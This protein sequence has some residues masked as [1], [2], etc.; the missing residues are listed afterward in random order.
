VHRPP[1]S[2]TLHDHRLDRGL[3]FDGCGGQLLAKLTAQLQDFIFDGRQ[4]GCVCLLG[5]IQQ[6]FNQ[7]FSFQL[8]FGF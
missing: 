2:G 1:T 4:I 7:T 3:L 5:P 8:H 6:G